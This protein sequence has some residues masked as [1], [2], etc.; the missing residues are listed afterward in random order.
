MVAPT[1]MGKDYGKINSVETG[2]AGEAKDYALFFMVHDKG[3]L[4]L[5][6]L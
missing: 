6:I 4:G 2:V 5:I 1:G 3:I